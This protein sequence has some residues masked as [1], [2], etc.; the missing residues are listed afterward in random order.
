M[1]IYGPYEILREVERKFRKDFEEIM[2]LR[3]NPN[4]K[5]YEYEK[6][7]ADFFRKYLGSV[8][9]FHIRAALVDYKGEYSRMLTPQENIYREI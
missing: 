2:R 8:Y 5:G 4:T 3:Y 1:G 7:A 6:I 9:D